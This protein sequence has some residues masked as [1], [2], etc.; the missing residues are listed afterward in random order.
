MEPKWDQAQTTYHMQSTATWMTHRPL[1]DGS[2]CVRPNCHGLC[3]FG[4]SGLF[5]FW[6]SFMI[7]LKWEA[8]SRVTERKSRI[9]WRSTVESDL[10]DTQSTDSGKQHLRACVRTAVVCAVLAYQDTENH[11][12][13]R[14]IKRYLMFEYT[15]LTTILSL[16]FVMEYK[17]VNKHGPP[18]V[19]CNGASK[20]KRFQ[21][22]V[23]FKR[24]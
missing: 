6:S 17:L 2:T 9:R 5:D 23:D 24:E 13:L 3:C 15:C 1:L 22:W 21:S 16:V 10:D 12:N 18:L 20:R 14:R 19:A 11:E 7:Q 4:L 8:S